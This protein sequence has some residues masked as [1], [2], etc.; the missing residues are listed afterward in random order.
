MLKRNVSVV[1]ASESPQKRSLLG[2]IIKQESGIEIIGEA[3]NATDALTM[4]RNLRP[5]VVILDSYLPR[6]VSP[7]EVPHQERDGLDVA[8]MIFEE[9]PKTK[10]MLLDDMDRPASFRGSVTPG[11]YCIAVSGIC[12]SVARWSGT[13]IN[14]GTPAP[15]FAN[16]AHQE[17]P[18]HQA[19]PAGIFDKL[20]FLGAVGFGAGWLLILT[21][22]LA[23]FGAPVA[24]L[25]ALTAMTGVLGK[26]VRSLWR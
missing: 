1:L 21:M 9:T 11:S 3:Q 7:A 2:Q 24:I 12:V 16:L 18:A 14:T 20:I 26:A 17:Y 23:N 19:K 22:F 5:N 4:T 10:V 25:G 13:R 15:V 6:S 8:R